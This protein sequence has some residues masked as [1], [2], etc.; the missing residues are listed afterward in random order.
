LI[1]RGY[2][3]T[4]TRG[5]LFVPAGTRRSEDFPPIIS[6]SKPKKIL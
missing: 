2:T 4:V 1:L 6:S 5:N 3:T